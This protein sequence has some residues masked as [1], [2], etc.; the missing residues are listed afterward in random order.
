VTLEILA[1]QGI[2]EVEAGDDIASLIVTHAPALLDGDVLVV[3]SKIVSKAEGQRFSIDREVAIDAETIRVVAR[4]GDT[5]IVQTRHGFVMAAAGVDE[6]NVT[7]GEVLVLPVDPDASARR[8]RDGVHAMAGV[9]VG[10]VISDTFGRPWRVGVTDGAVGFAGLLAFDDLRG[11]VDPYGNELH[12][13]LTCTVDE[14]AAA[15]DLVKGKVN[16]LPVASLRGLSVVLDAEIPTTQGV[17]D[18]VRRIEDDLFSLGTRDV[19]KARID[20]FRFAA[21]PVEPD[22]ITCGLQAASLA[23]RPVGWDLLRFAVLAA[24]DVPPSFC[25]DA[26]VPA[27][28]TTVIVPYLLAPPGAQDLL[29]AGAAIENVLI[30]LAIEQVGSCWVWLSAAT[31]PELAAAIGLEEFWPVGLIAVGQPAV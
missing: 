27:T 22:R 6:S 7:K 11:T 13:T 20:T 3:T 21:E 16:G 19:L 24:R 4:R 2:P 5:R 17:S 23:A 14:I 8:I 26:E 1:V 28:A 30:A 18:I 31:V 25:S 15:A 9:N 29:A 10:V 12:V